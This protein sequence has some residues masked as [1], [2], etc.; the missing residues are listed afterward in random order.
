MRENI[1]K[2]QSSVGK[3]MA[4]IFWDSEGFL[5]RSVPINSE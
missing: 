1:F 2:V 3:V 5:K 4:D